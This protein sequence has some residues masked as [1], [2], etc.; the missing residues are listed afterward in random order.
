MMDAIG[1]LG[2][3]MSLYSAADALMPA[4]HDLIR[5]YSSIS[6][7]M[8]RR[9]KGKRAVT[10]PGESD[11]H[12][13]PPKGNE[14]PVD[15]VRVFEQLTKAFKQF[16]LSFKNLHGYVNF[17]GEE[18]LHMLVGE[19]MVRVSA[20]RRSSLQILTTCSCRLLI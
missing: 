13:Y 9:K 2:S 10:E 14:P 5:F 12:H 7:E 4:L 20:L 18:R 11:D 19:I 15:A 8:Q 16:E 1:V 6:P 3:M 17:K